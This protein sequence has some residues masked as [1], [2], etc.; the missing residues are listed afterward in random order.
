MIR[1]EARYRYIAS[2]L[3]KFDDSLST[4]ETTVGV[5]WKF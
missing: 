2:L 5:G 3:E 1:A 4:V